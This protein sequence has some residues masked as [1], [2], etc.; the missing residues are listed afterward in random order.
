MKHYFFTFSIF[1]VTV[2]FTQTKPFKISGTLI[3]EADKIPLGF[4]A[5]SFKTKKE[6]NVEDLLNQNTN[7]KRIAT[8]NYI[9]DSQSTVLKQYVML[10]FSWKFKNF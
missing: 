3:A 1:C 6:A 8:K 10:S 7:A 9:Q 5:S 4:N 2:A